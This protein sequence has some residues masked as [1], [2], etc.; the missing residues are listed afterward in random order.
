M[1]VAQFQFIQC[2]SLAQTNQS[3]LQI[4]SVEDWLSFHETSIPQL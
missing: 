1:H 2:L 3:K 4:I